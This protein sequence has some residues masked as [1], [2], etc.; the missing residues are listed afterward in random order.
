MKN[1]TNSQHFLR[2]MPQNP[3]M[4]PLILVLQR[5]R[6][7]VEIT[8]MIEGQQTFDEVLESLTQSRQQFAEQQERDVDEKMERD[9][10]E[11]LR[12]QQEDDYEQSV[13]TDMAKD[14]VRQKEEVKRLDEVRRTEDLEQKRLVID[15]VFHRS[16]P[17]EE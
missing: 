17:V 1:T 9:S 12:K 16:N 2:M 11:K 3:N 14:R 15:F 6:G 8:N 13:K 7:A 4:F 5:N 10:R